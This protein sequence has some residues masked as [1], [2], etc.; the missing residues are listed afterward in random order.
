MPLQRKINFLKIT[1]CVMLAITI[2]LQG[3]IKKTQDEMKVQQEL[4]RAQ[5]I[6]R[7]TLENSMKSKMDSLMKL[8][9]K[10]P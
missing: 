5:Q 7:T 6:Y 10:K 1:I 9:P 3:A 8:L 2:L 4:I